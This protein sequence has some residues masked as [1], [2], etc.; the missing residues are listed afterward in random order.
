MKY[1]KR[2]V[3]IEAMQF[4]DDASTISRLSAFMGMEIAIDYSQPRHPIMKLSTLE[5]GI[6][7]VYPSDWIIK[8]GNG[9][10]S[11]CRPDVFEETYELVELRSVWR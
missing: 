9:E 1:R 3:I 4:F 5:G 8:N 10:F 2:P 11:S 6:I 7:D